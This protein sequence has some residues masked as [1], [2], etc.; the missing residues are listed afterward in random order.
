[1]FRLLKYY[2]FS[3]LLLLTNLTATDAQEVKQLDSLIQVLHKTEKP[4]DKIIILNLLSDY[5]KNND[6][7]RAINFSKQALFIAESINSWSAQSISQYQL[8][9]LLT[10]NKDNKYAIELLNKA[11]EGFKHDEEKLYLAKTKLLLGKYFKNS[12][13]YEKSLQALFESK[14]LFIEL[15]Q[16]D[17]LAETFNNIGGNYY[18][19]ND[20]DKASDY[21]ENS[22]EI[23]SQL[24]NLT[25]I[26]ML[27]N[28]LG[29]VHR[30]RGQPDQAQIHYK[31]AIRIN[32]QLGN[33]HFLAIN[34]ENMGSVFLSR[35]NFDSA[36]Y[37]LK[38]SLKYGLLENIPD[39]ISSAKITLGKLFFEADQYDS[40]LIFLNSGYELSKE[41]G[42]L[43]YQKNAAQ[44][45]GDFYANKS[46]FKKAL[47][48]ENEYKLLSDSISDIN[49]LEEIT[50]MEMKLIFDHE[51]ELRELQIQ[52]NNL[53]YFTLAVAIISL[54]IILILLYGRLQIATKRAIPRAQILKLEQQNLQDEI[55][56]KNR[57][58]AT[59]V[60]YMVK[61]NELIN[62]I[63][64]KLFRVKKD[65]KPAIEKKIQ[66]IILSLQ[67]NVDKDIWNVFQKRF[68]EVHGNFYQKLKTKFPILTEN[69]L[70][71][72]A[73][74]KLNMSTKEIA[75]ITQQNPNT[76]DVNRTR[77]RKKLDLSNQNI[78]LNN[79]LS[80]I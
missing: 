63:S 44:L 20:Y 10:Q 53:K 9:S 29:E 35:N 1:M 34:L 12:Y 59:N 38:R 46:D 37:F 57:E 50:Q 11:A 36:Q 39:V 73:F 51:Q 30:L 55:E 58:L 64:E 75:S 7:E 21:Y 48:F 79:F 28:N 61:K 47:A 14:D 6:P 18:D 13:Q 77:L 68:G 15:D 27:E 78:S 40:A 24:N 65:F 43:I 54:V 49:S 62:L 41:T 3:I 74:I 60:M 8:A 69:D 32:E 66:D 42:S 16:K 25:G 22:L 76:I 31:E 52:R 67:S 33:H 4:S 71:L 26:A 45:L 5:Y 80:N 19:Q 17:Y 23:Y 70:R 2:I 56:Y 72:C